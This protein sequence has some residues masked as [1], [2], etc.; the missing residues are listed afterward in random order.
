MARQWD[1]CDRA[2]VAIADRA[3]GDLLAFYGRLLDLEPQRHQPGRYGEFTLPGGLILAIFVPKPS[4]IADF[5]AMGPG[6][7][8]LCLQVLDLAAAIAQFQAAGGSVGPVQTASHGQ[9]AYGLDPQGN[10]VILYQP[11]RP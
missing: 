5:Q 1:G 10:R 8:S 4:A 3:G 7:M 11:N 6:G 9:E 2:V